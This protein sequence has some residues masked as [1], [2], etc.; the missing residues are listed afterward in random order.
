MDKSGRVGDGKWESGK[1]IGNIELEPF[2]YATSTNTSQC[3]GLWH[4]IWV[5]SRY[6]VE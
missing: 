6:R 5:N 2:L 3:K 1:Q 4:G